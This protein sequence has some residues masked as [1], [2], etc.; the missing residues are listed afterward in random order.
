MQSL[1]HLFTTKETRETW[2][3]VEGVSKCFDEVKEEGR[4]KGP[5]FHIKHKGQAT[6]ILGNDTLRD[7]EILEPYGNG[8]S[9]VID[10]FMH[11]VT[12][13][14][15]GSRFYIE[16]IVSNPIHDVD[17]L[18]RRQDI[19]MNLATS[20]KYDDIVTEMIEFE[21]DVRWLFSDNNDLST[22]YDIVYVNGW[23][24]NKLNK[25]DLVL[26]AYN[27]YRIIG[28]PLI[29]ILSP[30]AYI[31][32]PYIVLRMKFQVAIP[33][34]D[35]V[36]T[37]ITSFCMMDSLAFIS[38]S[39][40]R[41]KYLSYGLTLLF[42]FQGLF[43]SIEVSRASYKI[44][45]LLTERVNG[46][47]GFIRRAHGIVKELWSDEI[48]KAF[49]LDDDSDFIG[50]LR[51]DIPYFTSCEIN[52]D[53]VF[54]V[55]SNFGHQLSIFKFL[56]KDVYVPLIKRVY[57]ID[58][59]SKMARAQEICF[60]EYI[61]DSKHPILVMKGFTHPCLDPSTVVANDVDLSEYRGIILT[62]PN[63]GGKSTSIKAIMIAAILSQTFGICNAKKCSLTPFKYIS[64]QMNVPDVKG[65]M[66]LFEAEMYRSKM[67]FEVI[68][69]LQ[70]N[71][72]A[73]IAMDEIFSSTNPIEGIAGAYSVAKHLASSGKVA[74]IIS[75][76]YI[77]LARLTK[78]GGGHLFQN[79]K[80]EV[81]QDKDGHV[82][83]YPFK[84]KN[85]VSRQYIALELLKMNG[86]DNSV[87]QDAINIK[88]NLCG[89][90]RIKKDLNDSNT[91]DKE[92]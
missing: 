42:Y 38:P 67:N 69:S 12:K 25:N 85:G 59:L 31:I 19:M 14:L 20:W 35:Y 4:D 23:I 47:I 43:N 75:T 18:K 9:T 24:I 84:L 40:N 92:Q 1:K 73:L 60:T 66:S 28:S 49:C 48:V 29:G 81:I 55:F 16:S 62:G 64:T 68:Q 78:E 22:L 72:H 52:G 51:D 8:G 6:R 30:L 61:K 34:K 5:V 88:E 79:K 58:G 3:A 45:K 80:M 63:A 74:C 70:A 27:V 91:L 57:L 11:P 82:L 65:A 53:E 90:K 89:K 21:T 13:H 44:T 83:Y 2:A 46:I 86:F 36:R 17:V 39:V 7:L 41:L 33:F 77:Y 56:R 50:A 10:V 26:T 76:H 15:A 32:I 54:S 87:I 37:L 71:E